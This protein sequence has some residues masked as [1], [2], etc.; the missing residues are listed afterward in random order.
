MTEGKSLVV[1][2]HKPLALVPDSLDGIRQMAKEIARS[3]MAPKSYMRDPKREDQGYSEE[4]ITVGIMHGLEVGLT[5][6][7]AL[8]SIA[9]VN[10]MPT[11]WGDG[12]LALLLSSGEVEDHEETFRDGPPLKREGRNHGEYVEV[13]NP[14]A[15]C[16]F[17]RK[18]RER[19]IVREFGYAD[20][21]AAELLGKDTYKKYLKRMLQMRARAWAMRDAFSDIL[22]GLAI[23]EE[24]M[25]I[26][27][28]AP[29]PP[30]RPSRSKPPAPPAG[31]IDAE[32]IDDPLPTAEPEALET[33]VHDEDPPPASIDVEEFITGFLQQL[34]RCKTKDEIHELTR[35][36][37]EEIAL[38][39]LDR[40]TGV[41]DEILARMEAVER[42]PPGT[43]APAV[44]K[45]PRTTREPTTTQPP[46]SAAPTTVEPAFVAGS[47]VSAD[48]SGLTD[49]DISHPWYTNNAGTQALARCMI[50]V[51]GEAKT[52]DAL[53]AMMKV[54]ARVANIKLLEEHAPQLCMKVKGFVESHR[55]LL[56]SPPVMP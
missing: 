49:E 10:G 48:Y 54:E 33:A 52:E 35:F 12:A 4:K 28:E 15:V 25:D 6:M 41:Q 36:N 45:P 20:A 19:P 23:R 5:P 27:P 26:E 47:G 13:P 31:A 56:R 32:I 46:A 3:G 40:W 9:V 21:V 53:D 14:I 44:T 17:K 2:G 1:A 18:G 29:P 30:P 55:K 42:P 7:A 34:G 16:M 38:V 37:D 11:I 50:G 39:P 51:I 22:R 8:Q 24:A 43:L